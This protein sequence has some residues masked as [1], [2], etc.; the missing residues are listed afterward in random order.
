MFSI[1]VPVVKRAK[2][3]SV[4][5]AVAFALSPEVTILSAGVTALQ[6]VLVEN[7]APAAT[8]AVITTLL[9]VTL[10]HDDV[11]YVT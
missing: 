5:S 3:C 9:T 10:P 2:Y 1:V 6:L 11:S 8:A 4:V 7:E